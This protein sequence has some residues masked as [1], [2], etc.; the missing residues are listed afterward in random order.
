MHFTALSSV[1]V[2]LVAVNGANAACSYA[3][4]PGALAWNLKIYT[5]T[6]CTGQTY[7]YHQTFATATCYNI[8]APLNDNVNSFVFTSPI[9][10]I[11]LY[12]NAGCTGTELGEC[13]ASEG[14][15]SCS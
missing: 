14:T 8:A 1:I 4:F 11:T 15:I 3:P 7:Q 13:P 9:A 2:A 10:K 5:G 12:Q 6:G